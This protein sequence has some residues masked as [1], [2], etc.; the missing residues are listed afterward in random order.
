MIDPRGPSMMVPVSGN[1]TPQDTIPNLETPSVLFV[2]DLLE[3]YKSAHDAFRRRED[4]NHSMYHALDFGQWPSDLLSELRNSDDPRDLTQYNFV[5]NIVDVAVGT[6]FKNPYEVTIT[7][8]DPEVSDLAVVGQTLF[9]TDKELC[10]WDDEY[11]PIL[12]DAMITV[13]I[14]HL[15]VTREHNVLGNIALKHVQHGHFL[16]DPDWHGQTLKDCRRGITV[17]YMNPQEVA[18]TYGVSSEILAYRIAEM[19]KAIAYGTV[20]TDQSAPMWALEKVR[21]TTYRVTHYHHVERKKTTRRVAI[22]YFGR[23]YD[24][25]KPPEDLKGEYASQWV[26]SW[27]QINNLSEEQILEIDEFEDVYY[28]TSVCGD[29]VPDRALEDKPGELQLGRLPF[30]DVSACRH[31][32]KYIGV[33]DVV[34]GPQSGFNQRMSLISEII[35]RGAKDGLVF[36][37]AA[38][39]NDPAKIEQVKNE[40]SKPGF[41]IDTE[42]GYLAEGGRVFADIPRAPYPQLE[43]TNANMLLNI[44]Q[45]ITPINPAMLGR[46]ENAHETGIMLERKREQGEITMAQITH[47]INRFWEEIGEAYL[48]AASQVYGGVYRIVSSGNKIVELNRPE[49]APDGEIYLANDISLLPRHR[50][51]VALSAGGIS[52]RVNDRISAMELIRILPAEASASRFSLIR[53][54]VSTIDSFSSKER[55]EIDK[56]L[57]LEQELVESNLTANIANAKAMQAQAEAAIAQMS[58]PQ[59]TPEEAAAGGERI[60]PEL[61][62]MMQGSPAGTGEDGAVREPR[63][64]GM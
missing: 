34:G 11:L 35:A 36:D 38:F 5:K 61:M 30:F 47:S 10:R 57:A 18:D 27:L 8:V 7:A 23:T 22:D 13:G 2:E 41:R 39:G 48:R 14:A 42:S 20:D 28:I 51:V 49:T 60:P 54:A 9:Y 21:N 64:V 12:T 62:A 19:A 29:L 6:S 40:M 26:S 33:V 24:V 1:P 44:M 58:A 3:K 52:Q 56:L 31:D 55:D 16:P 15:C 25:P 45:Q 17:S 32:G 46:N 4:D 37:P 43:H 59:P 53:K 50:V 63:D